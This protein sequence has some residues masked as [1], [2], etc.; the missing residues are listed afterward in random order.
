MNY[1]DDSRAQGN[2]AENLLQSDSQQSDPTATCGSGSLTHSSGSVGDCTH[3]PTGKSQASAG[4]DTH[5]KLNF[6]KKHHCSYVG[7]L[8][9]NLKM[10]E[11]LFSS[12]LQS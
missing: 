7:A 3:V 11:V 2:P 12:Y 5:P 4:K 6:N 10:S 1:P 9:D 8:Q